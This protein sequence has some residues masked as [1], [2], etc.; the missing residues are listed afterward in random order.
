MLKRP[1]FVVLPM[2][3]KSLL[4]GHWSLNAPP[5]VR[6]HNRER[7]L[8]SRSASNVAS[9]V[10]NSLREV[11]NLLFSCRCLTWTQLDAQRRPDLRCAD[12]GPVRFIFNIYRLRSGVCTASARSE[13]APPLCSPLERNVHQRFPEEPSRAGRTIWRKE[14]VPSEFRET[15]NCKDDKYR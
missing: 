2:N 7:P 1:L 15:N 10:R 6:H 5:F 8:R 3:V 12:D 14:R 11:A 9:P 13:M 4:R